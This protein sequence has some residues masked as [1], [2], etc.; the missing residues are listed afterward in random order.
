MLHAD[1]PTWWDEHDAEL[2]EGSCA[3][4]VLRGYRLTLEKLAIWRD[5]LFE[6]HAQLSGSV[7]AGDDAQWAQSGAALRWSRSTVWSRAFNATLGGCRTVVLVP[8]SVRSFA[9]RTAF[10]G[11]DLS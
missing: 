3:A 9:C 11:R 7:S 4:P 8:V 2:L 10:F 6:L 1:D 5:R